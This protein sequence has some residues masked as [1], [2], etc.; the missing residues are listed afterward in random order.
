MSGML[1]QPSQSSTTRSPTGVDLRIDQRHQR[2]ILAVVLIV[3][4]VLRRRRRA[5]ETRRRTGA[6]SREPAAPP[7]RRPGIPSSSRTCR[8]S[9]AG[10]PACGSPSGCSGRAFARSTGCPMRAIFR[11]D[12]GGLYARQSA[13]CRW[14]TTTYRFCPA[15]GGPLETAAA[16]GRGSGAARVHAV[17]PVLYLDPK[18]AVGTIITAADDDRLVLVRRA[19]EP[20]YGLWVF[21]G[22]YVDRGEDVTAAARSRGARRS[23]P[24]GRLDG[25]VNIYSYPGRPLVIIVYCGDRG[26]RRAVHRRGVPRGA[27]VHAATRSRGTSWPFDSTREACAITSA[28]GHRYADCRFQRA[29]E[30]GIR[31]L[32]G[33]Q[34]QSAAKSHELQAGII[35]SLPANQCP[36]NSLPAFH[37]VTEIKNMKNR[38]LA[39]RAVARARRPPP[40]APALNVKAP[41]PDRALRATARCSATGPRRTWF[42]RRAPAPISSGTS[43][44][45]TGT[46]ARRD[47]SARPAPAI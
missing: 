28:D 15:C 46:S 17:R 33:A 21:P 5:A 31:R 13:R 1:R 3:F 23:R 6:G 24:R 29:R 32:R 44:E 20:G 27:A 4:V 2:H 9:A 45:Q 8:R 19:I 43:T 37:P 11:I 41:S 25:L 7:A 18:V 39:G 47:R 42:P 14:M 30:T 22:G 16:Q 36:G 12:I 40:A 38:I 34:P 35:L 26:R 10:S